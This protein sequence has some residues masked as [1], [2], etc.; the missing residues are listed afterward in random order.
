LGRGHSKVSRIVLGCWALGGGYTWGDQDSGRSI[1]TIHRALELGIN[2]FDT[3][4]FYSAGRSEELLGEALQ[5]RRQEAFVIT[6]LWT[7]NMTRD[8]AIRACEASLRRLRTDVIDLYL[9]HWPNRAVPLE[10]TL[11]A[12]EQLKTQG[13][14]RA[15]GVCNFG[16]ADLSQ[17]LQTCQIAADQLAYSLLFR[18]I[19]PEI[20]PACRKAHVGVLAYSPLAQGLLTGKFSCAGEVDDERART[21]F[22]SKARPG[23]VHGEAGHEAAV[24]AALSEIRG[25]CQELGKPM[26]EVAVAWVLRQEGVVAA[27]VGARTPEQIQANIQAAEI[28]L[29]AEAISRLNA[30]TDTLT[31]QMGANADMWRNQD[32]IR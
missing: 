5:G 31:Q 13:K 3:A 6:K 28:E 10:E 29:P 18:A 20:L 1:A 8:K 25:I 17:A 24:F 4:E 19:E 12:M 23:T 15:I 27:L 21:R 30:A 26:A 32:R 22:Y 7:E 16:A 2:A 14:A 9:I 11:G